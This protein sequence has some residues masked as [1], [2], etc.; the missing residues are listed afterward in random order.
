MSKRYGP[1]YDPTLRQTEHGVSLYN[2]WRTVRRHPHCEEW[3]YFPTFYDWSLQNGF[4]MGARLQTK[5]ADKPFSPDNCEWLLLQKHD[6]AEELRWIK[7]WNK[8]VNRIRKHYGLP[9]IGGDDDA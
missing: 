2:A 3:E 5:D 6:R 8:T 4:A 1:A 9:L 7:Q